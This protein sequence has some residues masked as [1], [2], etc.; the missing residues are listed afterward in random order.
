MREKGDEWMQE[1][2]VGT[3]PYKLVKWNRKQE[4]VLVRNEDYWGPKPAFKYVQVRIIPE[5]GHPDRRADLG[6]RGHH[7]GGAARP[8]GR[9]Q[10]VG[11]GPHLD[12]ADPAHGHPPA[13][14]GRPE[15]AEPVHR[16]AGAPGGEPRRRHGRDHQARAQRPRRPRG[17]RGQ[18]DGVRLGREHQALQAGPRAGQEA[19]G[20]GRLPE[21]LST[22]LP[23]GR[24]RGA[25]DQQT[26]EA[27]V[28]D[29]AKAGF[30]VKRNYIGETPCS[31]PGSR[32]ARPA[33][34]STGRGATTRCST[35]TPSS[36]TSS[37]A[38]E[39]QLLLQQGAR[40][41]DHRRAAPR[42][43]GRSGPRST[44]RPRSCCSTTPPTST[45]G[46]CAASGASTTGS[47]TRRPA[48]EIDRMYLVTPRKR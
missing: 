12:L 29:M 7:Q 33:T 45:S 24:G 47:S 20:R 8:D 19:A 3:G 14:P 13:G 2:P 26:N 37:S 40:R 31:W 17:Y 46:A 21:W 43:T 39:Q 4:H 22:F 30:R 15:R 5:T 1:N 16:Q 18:P 6:R 35:P 42:W 48:D 23:R 28:A 27:I 32:R 38:R 34:C 44:P 11:A 41:P 36:S 10:Q 9:R 25:R